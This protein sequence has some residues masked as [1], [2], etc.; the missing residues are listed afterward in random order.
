[1]PKLDQ[2]PESV[3]AYIFHG[4]ELRYNGDSAYAERCPWCGG[5]MKWNVRLDTGQ[6]RCSKCVQGNAKDGGNV[7]TFLRMLHE[8]ATDPAP[9]LRA[10]ATGRKLLSP[11]TLL[12]WGVGVSYLTGEYVVPGYGQGGK[13]DQLYPYRKNGDG[14]H[15]LLCTP[16]TTHALH[17]VNLYDPAKP[18]VFLCEGPWDG[19][20][21]WEVLRIAKRTEDG[22]LALT[23]SEANSLYATA[24]V[25][26]CPG[27]NVF[28]PEWSKFFAGK[29]VF[30]MYDNDHPRERPPGSG[31]F[32]QPGLD[33]M[34]RVAAALSRAEEGPAEVHWLD[35]GGDDKGFN[36]DFPSGFDVRDAVTFGG[37]ANGGERISNLGVLLSKTK[38]IPTD[39][40]PGRTKAAGPGG[41]D[42]TTVR[43]TSWKALIDAWR[44]PMAWS[45]GLDRALSCMLA[46]VISVRAVG[47]QLWCRILGPASC[48]DGGTPIHDP[49]DGTTKTVRQRQEEGRKF[50]V[51]TMKDR[52]RVGIAQ[53]LPPER[54][55]PAPMY[56]LTFRSG[57]TLTVTEGHRVWD[58]ASYVSVRHFADRLRQ[59]GPCPLPTIPGTV[60]STR[61]PGAPRSSRTA[62]GYQDGY[63]AYPYSGGGLLPPAEGIA[64]STPP[65]L[66]GAPRRTQ[67]TSYGDDL[68]S[69]DKCTRHR[70]RP[71]LP[72]SSSDLRLGAYTLGGT[73]AEPSTV[74]DS[75]GPCEYSFL[76]DGH[77]PKQTVR[78]GTGRRV[79]SSASQ[80]SGDG[81]P[82]RDGG[83]F[84][85]RDPAPTQRLPRSET[86]SYL[87]RTDGDTGRS[88]PETILWGRPASVSPPPVGGISESR[89]C[90]PSLWRRSQPGSY[91][92]RTGQRPADDAR[93]TKQQPSDVSITVVRDTLG[94]VSL[95]ETDY[96][97]KVEA[98]GEAEY[99]DFHVPETNNYWAEGVFNHNCGKS[100]LCEALS[101]A[102]KY[103]TAKSTIRGFHSGFKTDGGG[104][105]DNSLL[106]LL[107]N[108]TL[109]TK[110]GDT[111]LQS[112]E[113]A[114]ILSEARDVYDRVSRTHYR[115]GLS[116]D[117]EGINMTWI[118]CGTLSL[119]KLDQ[120]ELGERFLTSIIMDG[121]DDEVED[122][123]LMKV[124]HRVARNMGVEVGKGAAAQNDPQMTRAMQM[125]GG[126]VE[127]LRENA[128]ELLGRVGQSDEA[129]RYC[130]RLAKFVAH[131]RARP[132]S[133]QD[134]A[135]ERE[136]AYRLASQLIRLATCTAAVLNKTTL[137]A[138][139]LRRV[140][141]VALD[142][143]RGV[144][145]D[146]VRRMYDAG[147][148]GSDVA[149]LATWTHQEDAKTTKLMRF[150]RRE[151]IGVVEQFVP[152][153]AQGLRPRKRWR[154]TAKFKKLWEDVH[155]E[156][157]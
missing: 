32:T 89:D 156:G 105:K 140:R 45:D 21:L 8:R 17:G 59:H 106:A 122:E 11:D 84:P 153:T 67:W 57:R 38:P 144:T 31:K 102:K 118:L 25:L 44:K 28:R 151:T 13:L 128:T 94:L 64:Q 39:W 112:P 139:V 71:G 98:V 150:L 157:E 37:A 95:A 138:E 124:A 14:R 42:M 81:V 114:R 87:P 75:A 152:P 123:I 12:A 72:S 136:A 133:H 134:E 130:T 121:I 154:L 62:G 6:W 16:G 54:F 20:A 19:M 7:T 1:M 48:L 135:A 35:W 90:P 4:V 15:H 108:M 91:P 61:R 23:S 149:S 146:I 52:S 129:L 22:G 70:V 30:L 96:L 145:F 18:D 73:G 104:E 103:I 46:S 66:D 93:P 77:I 74:G 143:S 142:T 36:P 43:C 97:V 51:Y 86:G 47:D 41:T 26:A 147:D 24:N 49:V 107:N 132:S 85:R 79:P 117:Y 60:L 58:G 101:T 131:L 82:P 5:K 99:F 63:R 110:D 2:T 137:D 155:R 10:L 148:E 111:L 126:Y 80:T 83:A 53:A 65:S 141:R 125:T 40:I 115:H 34:R 92:T 33:G 76:T 116:R 68:E 127:Y 119:L 50:F 109:V 78:T 120:S 9:D 56:R 69:G 88:V 3:R 55:D 100:V 29:R 27:A 113:L